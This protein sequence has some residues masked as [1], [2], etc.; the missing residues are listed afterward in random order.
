MDRYFIA[1]IIGTGEPDVDEWRLAVADF[2]GTGWGWAH[3]VAEIPTPGNWA[4]ARVMIATPEGLEAMSNDIRLDVLPFLE[5]SAMLS[6]QD[7]D[8]VSAALVR[9]NIPLYALDQADTFGDLL[10]NLRV[11]ALAQ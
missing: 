10:E 2:P 8:V 11:S 7:R 5:R 9:R 3:M 1:D 4:V 6:Q